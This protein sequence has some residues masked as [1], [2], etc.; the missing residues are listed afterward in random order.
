M[1]DGDRGEQTKLL[2]A[3]LGNL[4]IVRKGQVDLIT[5]GEKGEDFSP[6]R[7]GTVLKSSVSS[8]PIAV[9]ECDERGSPRRC[10]GQG[11]LLSGTIGLFSHWTKTT[12]PTQ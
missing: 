7:R 1:G 6:Q 12:P 8:C 10:G 2:A 11:D 9:I 5:N 4:V 3:K